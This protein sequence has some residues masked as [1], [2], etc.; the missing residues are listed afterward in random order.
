MSRA[1]LK[2]HAISCIKDSVK[3][4]L[5]EHCGDNLTVS[6][7]RDDCWD[8]RELMKWRQAIN[9]VTRNDII[10]APVKRPRQKQGLGQIHEDEN[11][12]CYHEAIL[13]IDIEAYVSQCDCDD[14]LNCACMDVKSKA[15]AIMGH[16]THVL[17]SY[18]SQLLGKRLLYQ[19]SESAQNTESENDLVVVTGS[20]QIHYLFDQTRPWVVGK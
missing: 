6:C 17:T 4:L 18:Q 2:P 20:F 19:G 3:A 14:G 1:E 10:N 12:E 11:L 5:D 8:D 7:D 16:I 9:I 15:H 13:N